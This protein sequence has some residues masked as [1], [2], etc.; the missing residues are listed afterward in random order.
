MTD[1]AVTGQR[2]D[3]R[4]VLVAL[5]LFAATLALLLATMGVGFTR[6]ESFYFHAAFQYLGWFKDLW[7]NWHAGHLAESFTKA[8]IDHHWSYN[9]EHPVLMKA[10]FAL[11]YALFHEKLGWMSASTA[12]RFPAA[13]TA[14][15][16]ISCVYLFGRQLHGRAAGLVAAGAMLLQPRFF[17]HAHMAAFDV[18]ITAF[19]VWTVYAYWR[20][21]ESRGWAVATG[22][23][24]GLAL[25]VKLNAFFIPFVLGLHWLTANWRGFGLP[26]DP[27]TGR[28]SVRIGRFPLAFLSMA[29][30]GTLLFHLLWPRHWFDT[31]D[32]VKW[33]ISFH[34]NHVHYFVYYFGQNIQQPPLPISYPWVMTLLTVPA[35][36]LLAFGIGLFYGARRRRLRKDARAT[37]VLLAINIIFPIALISLPSTPIFGGTKHWMQAM[38]FLAIVAGGGVVHAARAV[39]DDR[40]L[41]HAAARAAVTALLALAVLG[42]AAYATA[43]SHPFGTSYYN[44]L[45]GSYRGAADARMFRQFWGYAG[46]YGLDWLDANA[47]KRARVYTHNTTGYAWSMYR[48]DGLV[49]KDLRPSSIGG[50]DYA[51]FHY[52]KAFVYKL[53]DIWQS[54]GTMTPARVVTIDGVPVLAIY[55]RRRGTGN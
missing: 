14:A 45:I 17:F 19:W 33:Y 20:S 8:N 42:P 11:S 6:D 54:Y 38:P 44:E 55:E 50:S 15:S 21:L 39:W 22:V 28:R 48:R 40:H 2:L 47:P 49:R 43:E 29:V 10:A 1:T 35:T 5:A 51:L 23:L 4:D 46:R 37:G 13:V 12:M 32:R 41:S 25:S 30:L 7:H 34:L 27:E 24:W 52:Q 18:P 31:F 53:I 16:L 9:R 26:R 36:I 3:G